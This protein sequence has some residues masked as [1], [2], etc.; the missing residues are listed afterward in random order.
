MRNH[1]HT[2]EASV[3]YCNKAHISGP[4][5]KGSRRAQGDLY[6]PR[7]AQTLVFRNK[8]SFH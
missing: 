5:T 6:L 1:V 3:I 2:T 7:D 4:Q 8:E